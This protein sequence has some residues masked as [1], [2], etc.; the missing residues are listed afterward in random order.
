MLTDEQLSRI[1]DT[2][3]R[4]LGQ[5]YGV[6]TYQEM[7]E[8]LALANRIYAALSA[9]QWKYLQPTS[10]QTLMPGIE[11]VQVYVHPEAQELTLKAADESVR[12]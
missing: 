12:R 11:G 9:A 3:K 8:P 7:K 4:F 2:L 10:W 5:E 1:A 6:T